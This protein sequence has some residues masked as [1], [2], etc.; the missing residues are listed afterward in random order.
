MR[1]GQAQ[2]GAQALFGSLSRGRQ[3]PTMTMQASMNRRATMN[4]EGGGLVGNPGQGGGQGQGGG[5]GQGNYGQQ[6]FHPFH[7]LIGH[8]TSLLQNPGQ[9]TNDQHDHINWMH[10]RLQQL[11][12]QTGPGHLPHYGGRQN[13]YGQ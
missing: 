12:S 2:R 10:Q 8:Y 11:R 6:E 3:R 9:L 7:G 4:R 5:N 13:S 1:Y